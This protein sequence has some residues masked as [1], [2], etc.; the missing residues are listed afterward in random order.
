[1]SGPR[2]RIEALGVNPI[3]RVLLKHAC[4]LTNAFGG[5]AEDLAAALGSLERRQKRLS[6]V[7]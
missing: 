1:M 5:E 4:Q 6:R 2:Y 7:K 3:L